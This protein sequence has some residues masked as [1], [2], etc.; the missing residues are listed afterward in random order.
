MAR[1]VLYT[2][3]AAP[4]F[5]TA[6]PNAKMYAVNREIATASAAL[7]RAEGAK[8]ELEK[9]VEWGKGE[10]TPEERQ[11][12]SV[13]LAGYQQT[14]RSALDEAAA[15]IEAARESAKALVGTND[16]QT[17]IT[18]LTSLRNRHDRLRTDV[19]SAAPLVAHANTAVAKD[20]KKAADIEKN[21][22]VAE[23][24][25]Q[26]TAVAGVVEKVAGDVT[27]SYDAASE[28]LRTAQQNAETTRKAQIQAATANLAQK[29][30]LA[31]DAVLV[32]EGTKALGLADAV[33][34]AREGAAHESEAT[35][36]S[37]EEAIARVEAAE[38]AL[39]AV[40]EERDQTRATQQMVS[41]RSDLEAADA[42]VGRA[43]KAR[44][45]IASAYASTTTP[46]HALERLA[47]QR[48]ATQETKEAHGTAVLHAREIAALAPSIEQREHE[49]RAAIRRVQ[50]ALESATRYMRGL[51]ALLAAASRADELE[52]AIASGH[53]A[54]KA[55]HDEMVVALERAS[56]GMAD[57]AEACRGVLARRSEREAK[58][59][60]AG[61]HSAA[62]FASA[63]VEAAARQRQDSSVVVAA[64]KALGELARL[65]AGERYERAAAHVADLAAHSE[66]LGRAEFAARESI[67]V[68]RPAID[69]AAAY[70]PNIASL[71]ATHAALDEMTESA[72]RAVDEHR[73][74]AE[75]IRRA[76]ES[77]KALTA[78][79][80]QAPPDESAARAKEASSVAKQ[81]R[82][83]FDA[84][85]ATTKT[86]AQLARSSETAT[87]TVAKLTPSE[88][89]PV[90]TSAAEIARHAARLKADEE[91]LAVVVDEALWFAREAER[92][93]GKHQK[94][95]LSTLTGAL[96]SAVG[97][98]GAVGA[99]WNQPTAPAAPEPATHQAPVTSSWNQAPAAATYQAPAAP[100]WNPAPA[101]QP[102]PAT[103][104]WNQAP[105]ASS[106]NQAPAA[107]SYRAQAATS[108]N[109]ARAA[110]SAAQ[111][112]TEPEETGP[113]GEPIAVGEQSLQPGAE[114]IRYSAKGFARDGV[115]LPY[116]KLGLEIITDSKQKAG[117][118]PIRSTLIFFSMGAGKTALVHAVLNYIVGIA[119]GM[120]DSAPASSLACRVALLWQ[121]SEDA[122]RQREFL[123]RNH[124]GVFTSVDVD[125]DAEHVHDAI[126]F[127]SIDPLANI[128]ELKQ[129]LQLPTHEW[130]DTFKKAKN[131]G[132]ADNKQAEAMK[133]EMK[134]AQDKVR[135]AQ[136]ILD[137]VMNDD[138]SVFRPPGTNPKTATARLKSAQAALKTLEEKE[139]NLAKSTEANKAQKQ[140]ASGKWKCTPRNK[141]LFVVDECH[142]LF[143]DGNQA[144]NLIRTCVA[145]DHATTILMSGTPVTSNDPVRELVRMC[146]LLGGR[147]W[148]L[149]ALSKLA[150]IE[151]Q[152]TQLASSLHSSIAKLA[153][154]ETLAAVVQTTL[155]F[156]DLTNAKYEALL[157]TSEETLT[158]VDVALSAAEAAIT[159]FLERDVSKR[160]EKLLALRLDGK[161]LVHISYYGRINGNT[162]D[163]EKFRDDF[164]KYDF[165][166]VLQVL[167]D[168]H[169]AAVAAPDTVKSDARLAASYELVGGAYYSR[170][171]DPT[172]YRVGADGSV[173]RT[174][175][176]I[177]P[178]R[179]AHV[180]GSP[181]HSAREFAPTFMPGRVV[182]CLHVSVPSVPVS[183]APPSEAEARDGLVL[184]HSFA[185]LEQNTSPSKEWQEATY[186]AKLMQIKG[187]PHTSWYHFVWSLGVV[188]AAAC[189]SA[190]AET[191]RNSMVVYLDR[192]TYG[193]SRRQMELLVHAVFHE[194]MEHKLHGKIGR[195]GVPYIP[196][197][198]HGRRLVYQI[199]WEGETIDEKPKTMREWLDAP[200]TT[201]TSVAHVPDDNPTFRPS[202][203]GSKTKKAQLIAS[204]EKFLPLDLSAAYDAVQGS[205]TTFEKEFRADVTN[206]SKSRT[207]GQVHVLFMDMFTDESTGMSL[208]TEGVDLGSYGAICVVSVPDGMMAQRMAQLLDRIN[209]VDT[210]I[211]NETRRRKFVMLVTRPSALFDAKSPLQTMGNTVLDRTVDTIN[212]LLVTNAYDCDMNR[213]DSERS[214]ACAQP[215]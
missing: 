197:A 169:V 25:K 93:A 213:A 89:G 126:F 9:W 59:A 45:S 162:L 49:V 170:T 127:G 4:R 128:N 96:S 171:I 111:A 108:W 92:A 32:A 168:T 98:V 75:G 95:F 118:R 146:M 85:V 20:E 60:L 38:T 91:Q 62:Q 41:A 56:K 204:F 181:W 178:G 107:A 116:Q 8:K 11:Q 52:A 17:T 14:A 138:D 167:R 18:R 122:K 148:T 124:Y 155:S 119:Y 190:F 87:R 164:E 205:T 54:A 135:E 83:M 140:R 215:Y 166:T 112:D 61:A 66:R 77:V 33:W 106:W 80:Q 200:R 1:A 179:L 57:A 39:R 72:K 184:D 131:K 109:Q 172:A 206:A 16:E 101:A 76:A 189:A 24:V 201:T 158:R 188:F 30:N 73:A 100:S 141:L 186:G 94:G 35:M 53:A 99:S 177:Q 196:A 198:E 84:V 210:S 34:R 103:S 64:T 23:R 132:E 214:F 150:G 6:P 78:R 185:W 199:G 82:K 194:K 28:V 81:T 203:F 182:R 192:K 63:A 202:A 36:R 37:T 102:A 139:K 58:D 55:K 130:Y 175:A 161:R 195:G 145:C 44:Q 13:G 79:A 159:G 3:D 160:A 173:V 19:E 191:D 110:S 120:V 29:G 68:A 174:R 208:N 113:G 117:V 2:Y 12:L 149:E 157:K 180:D 5:G 143:A 50:P 51:P 136:K 22:K 176:A 26:T 165:A 129:Q 46:I 133:L 121:S 104:S 125:K 123:K 183:F 48:K 156:S 40:V 207:F 31:V 144:Y 152:H 15:A 105:A 187:A 88:Q 137:A 211:T 70:T 43:A 86:M 10:L 134:T 97:A 163:H 153:R 21:A 47:A 71:V 209:R 142:K 69:A 67:E 74:L 114:K 42:T 115:L 7:N 212:A 193:L 65:A 147:K 154:Y 27:R 151:P 90:A